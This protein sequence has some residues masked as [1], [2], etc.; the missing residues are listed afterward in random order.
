M[1]QVSSRDTVWK[2]LNPQYYKNNKTDHYTPHLEEN[3]ITNWLKQNPD[4]QM[5]NAYK[6]CYKFTEE[7]L[8]H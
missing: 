3:F 2:Q 1:T 8:K 6:E 4:G 7:E 5:Y